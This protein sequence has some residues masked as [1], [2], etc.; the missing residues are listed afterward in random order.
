M[1]VTPY[2]GATQYAM[3]DT[4]QA[5][6]EAQELITYTGLTVDFTVSATDGEGKPI[7]GTTTKYIKWVNAE[8]EI[9][10]LESVALQVY[11]P[12]RPGQLHRPRE[13]GGGPCR[14]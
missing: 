8:G 13:P 3:A 4:A 2:D 9:V 6:M 7:A 5:A 1:A 10:A 12:R 11:T 14:R